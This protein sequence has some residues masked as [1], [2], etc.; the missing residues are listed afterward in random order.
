MPSEI[1]PAA[2]REL[3]GQTLARTLEEAAF[4]FAEPTEDPPPFDADVIAARLAYGGAHSGELLL[5]APHDLAA[6]LAANLLGE[7]EGGASVT[8]DD[9][10]AVGEILNMI[11]G[12][13]VLELFGPDV[14]CKLGL[15]RVQRLT[16]EEY[17]RD[18]AG[19]QAA[20]TLVEEEGR[21]VD[22]SVRLAAGA[23]R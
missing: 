13:F 20:A 22:L 6:T 16:P 4:V 18:L 11:A 23:P 19:A 12:A 17:R 8:G 2:F 10:D 21:R 3:L 5:A 14:G 1:P 9:L 15:P 7:E